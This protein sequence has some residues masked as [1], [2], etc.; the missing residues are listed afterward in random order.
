MTHEVLLEVNDLV[1]E[2]V[3]DDGV[4]RVLDGVNFTVKKGQT[5]G[6]VGESGCGK[7]V[8]AMSVMGLL[9][10]P[11]G[12]V[13]GGKIIY[14][15]ANIVD[16]PPEKLYAMRGNRISMIFQDPMTALNP[17]HSIGKQLCEVL[18]LHRRDLDKKD[19]L[20]FAIDM[21]AKVGIPSPEQRISEYPHNLSGGMR[22]RVM[23]AIALACKPDI[24][25]CD[26]PTTALDVTVQAQILDLMR[27]LQRDTGMA[28][29]F[30]THDLGVVAEMCDD[31]VVMYAGRVVEM[32]DIFTL[33]E[34][35][36]HPYTL[37][38]LK[39]MPTQHTAHKQKLDTI[40]G[41]VP[42]LNEMPDGCR[43]C[44]R[45][46]YATDE[47]RDLVPAWT[48]LKGSHKVSCHHWMEV[49]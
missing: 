14:R 22:Q 11:Y 20:K 33:F 5:L 2:F 7:S 23:I 17:V 40:A 45:C 13:T 24:L 16:L 32:A 29:I 37:G 49:S 12:Q 42:P 31:V 38:L 3:T 18:E 43:F 21:L 34:K 41:N 39:S 9:P 44:T 15:G 1:T 30:I 26:E 10:R 47:C 48:Q 35:P 27:E 19:R 46:R 28:I 4:V 36:K 6:I 8:T 25:I